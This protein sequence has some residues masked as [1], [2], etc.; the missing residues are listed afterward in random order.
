MVRGTRTVLN[1]GHV[2]C[3]LRGTGLRFLR[4]G[5]C[6]PLGSGKGPCDVFLREEAGEPRVSIVEISEPLKSRKRE[7]EAEP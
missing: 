1:C 4:L 3:L 5:C 2:S 7:A 6:L